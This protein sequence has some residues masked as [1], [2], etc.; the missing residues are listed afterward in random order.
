MRTRRPPNRLATFSNRNAIAAV[1]A[2]L[3]ATATSASIPQPCEKDPDAAGGGSSGVASSAQGNATQSAQTPG[4]PGCEV[5]CAIVV[6]L[7][8]GG[9]SAGGPGAGGGGPGNGAGGGGAGS[10]AG[11]GGG[12]GPGDVNRFTGNFDTKFGPDVQAPSAGYRWFSGVTYNGRQEVRDTQDP[13]STGLPTRSYHSS[14]GY[15]GRNW[16]QD[17]QPELVITQPDAEV[18]LRYISLI[19]S[20][21]FRID[22]IQVALQDGG[23][24]WY[25]NPAAGINGNPGALRF[26]PEI[27]TSGGEQ[28]SLIVYTDLSGTEYTFFGFDCFEGTNASFAHAAGQL[29]KVSTNFGVSGQSVTSYVGHPTDGWTA[30]SHG[31][32]PASKGITYAVDGAGNTFNYTYSTQ[33]IGGNYRLLGVEA[34]TSTNELIESV[35][36]AYYTGLSGEPDAAHG[37]P[38]DLKLITTTTPTSV[39]GQTVTAR[40]YF[41]YYTGEYNAT[42]NPGTDHLLKMII[43]PEGVRQADANDGGGS[44]AFQSQTDGW[45]MPYSSAFL[46]YEK[47]DTTSAPDKAVDGTGGI[48]YMISKATLNGQCGC[49]GGSPSGTFEYSYQ[50]N[51]HRNPAASPLWD[52]GTWSTYGD[53]AWFSRTTVKRPDGSHEV[54]YFSL[55]ERSWA[56]LN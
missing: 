32:S 22:F 11:G 38:G 47:R 42:T 1:L 48:D 6:P 45:L 25:E 43:D 26:V 51:P 36:Y 19:Y 55:S 4:T 31:Y 52:T 49:G 40:R 21:N 18:G 37:L 27:T 39:V 15:Q 5:D 23:I 29:W 7:K 30:I 2:S 8:E 54:V 17:S 56:A 12:G 14:N 44:T 35:Q 28:P 13:S 10:G 16:F 53:Y 46:E 50:I 33:P 24:D 3:V 41:R 34:L 20:A 9:A